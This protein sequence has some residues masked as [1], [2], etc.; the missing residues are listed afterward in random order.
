MNSTKE[1]VSYC[2]GLETGKSL[3]Q[4]FADMDL[5]LVLEG[6]TDAIEEKSLKL[7]VEEVRTVMQALKQQIEQ[8]QRN[9]I[10]KASEENKKLG[11]AF[12]ADN[13]KK[14]DITTLP[15][16]L[17]YKVLHQGNGPSPTTLDI[18]QTHYRGYF[19]DGRVFDS[20]YE[21]GKPQ[22]FPVNRVI[23]GW[24][25]ALKMM[26]V[27]DKWQIF[28]PSYLAYGEVGFGNDIGPNMTLI[29]EMELL[30]INP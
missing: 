8:Q 28:I 12:L 27:G 3:K 16:G 4:Q 17:Q 20:S 25:E 9:Y 18:V 23:A 29:F 14:E 11:E 21:R 19:L 1:K 22:I 26:K 6:F 24:S 30:G 2:I 5:T 7:P 10:A 13:K 15:S